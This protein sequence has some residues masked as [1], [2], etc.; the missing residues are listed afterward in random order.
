MMRI[1]SPDGQ[2]IDKEERQ[3]CASQDE[4]E[5]G[6]RLS[7]EYQRWRKKSPELVYRRLID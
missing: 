6:Y 1:A 2:V 4:E 5:E 3:E 7:L